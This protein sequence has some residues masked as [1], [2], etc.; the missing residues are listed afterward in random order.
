M[1]WA[2]CGTFIK[3]PAA[4]VGGLEHCAVHALLEQGFV[5]DQQYIQVGPPSFLVSPSVFKLFVA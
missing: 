5:C 3:L 2:Q 1:D 4:V